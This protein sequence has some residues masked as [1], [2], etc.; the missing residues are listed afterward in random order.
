MP[1]IHNLDSYL[2]FFTDLDLT[3]L[4]YEKMFVK[5]SSLLLRVC[6]ERKYLLSDLEC[7]NFNGISENGTVLYI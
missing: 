6:D 4:N 1:K 2:L 3:W 7:D 5:R